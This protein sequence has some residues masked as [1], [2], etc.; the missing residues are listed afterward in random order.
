MTLE[1]QQAEQQAAETHERA[2]GEQPQEAEATAPAEEP[3]QQ[4]APD[5]AAELEREREKATDYM[6][7]WQRAQADLANYKRR[8]EQ[9]REQERKYAGAPIFLELLKMQDNFY[10]AFETLPVELREF[11]WVQGVALTYA[12]LDGLLQLYGLKPIETKP[13]QPFDPAVHEAVTHEETDAYPDGAITA[14]YQRG[15]YIH[16]R[17]LRPALVR[18]AKA[19][20]AGT[21]NQTGQPEASA[22]TGK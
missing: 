2:A 13:G 7:R 5:L 14:E 8:A 18:V 11:S 19:K 21:P 4:A 20:S 16:D 10:R 17:V 3:A 9:E 22:S 1:E 6:N 12:H 15:Y